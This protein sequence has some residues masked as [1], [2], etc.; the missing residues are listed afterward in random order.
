MRFNSINDVE[1]FLN[2]VN[3]L[4]GAIW[5]ESKYGDKYNLKSKLTQYVAMGELIKGHGDELE[6]FASHPESEAELVR[7]LGEHQVL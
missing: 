3:R 7:F 6:L 4:E 1:A 5:L 2:L